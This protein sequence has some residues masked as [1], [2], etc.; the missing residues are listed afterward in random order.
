MPYKV[1]AADRFAREIIAILTVCVARS[2]RLMGRPLGRTVH[3]IYPHVYENQP[4]PASHLH[5]SKE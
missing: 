2:R 5:S 3:P 1:H 4:S